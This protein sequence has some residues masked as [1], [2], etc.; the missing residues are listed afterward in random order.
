MSKG[1]HLASPEIRERARQA[2]A[3]SPKVNMRSLVRRDRVEGEL[4]TSRLAIQNFCRSCL[5]FEADD[6]RTLRASVAACEAQHCW[7]WPYRVGGQ[8]KEED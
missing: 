8:V 7:L 4:P 5:G 2:K 3:R 6:G 1:S